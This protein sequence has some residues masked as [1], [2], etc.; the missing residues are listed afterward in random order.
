MKNE[1]TNLFRTTLQ[2][3]GIDS[4]GV[5]D[6]LDACRKNGCELH[7][8]LIIRDEK[9]AFETC[10]FPY[11]PQD[12]RHVY[13]ISKS[14]TATA[15]GMAVAEGRFSLSD[16]V[17]SF[18]PEECPLHPDEN[19]MNME[20]RDLLRMGC[21]HETEPPVRRTEKWVH[22]FFQHPVPNKPGTRFL[23]NTP[24]SYILAAIVQKVT[25]QDL[26]DYLRPRLFEPLGIE[27]VYWEHSPEGICCGG[28]G[29]HVSAEDIAK[30]G[31]VY[32]NGGRWRGKQILSEEW[33]R[34]ATSCQ[35]DNAPNPNIDWKQ[36]Y[37][38]QIWR[39]QHDCFRFDGAYGQYMVA[40]PQ[41][42]AVVVALSY[43][44]NMQVFLDALWEYLLPAF[45]RSQTVNEMQWT[46]DICPIPQRQGR[47]FHASYV[48][49]ENQW[50]IRSV[51]A[52][53][54]A[55]GGQ[56]RLQTADNFICLPFGRTEWKRTQLIQCPVCPDILGVRTSPSDQIVAAAGGWN[57][58]QLEIIVRYCETPHTIVWRLNTGENTLTFLGETPAFSETDGAGI[59]LHEVKD[60][61]DDKD[62]IHS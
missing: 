39:C 28:F 4:Q 55:D 14:W 50:G 49:K 33:V 1:S 34:E 43:T 47:R 35:I 13:S 19:L 5:K 40:I 48:C 61:G 15:V 53:T 25:G 58:E 38:Y 30:L 17:V 26:I 3:A 36:G 6:F 9:I 54:D 27:K 62:V 46:D 10:Y 12:K 52:D 59:G 11:Q 56:I 31:L 45:D 42:N 24:A 18:F 37:G 2:Q 21:G 20:V 57:G 7:Q 41:K 32:L 23:Y 8:V 22:A 44:P 16:K 51:E 60:G 29:I